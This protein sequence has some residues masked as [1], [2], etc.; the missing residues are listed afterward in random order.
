MEMGREDFFYHLLPYS[1]SLYFLLFSIFQRIWTISVFFIFTAGVN[2]TKL[3]R[4]SLAI[5]LVLF[6]YVLQAQ[7]TVYTYLDSKWKKY[8]Q[9]KANYYRKDY[10]NKNKSWIVTDYYLDGQLQMSGVYKE[11]KLKTRNGKFI[12]YYENGNKE[13]EGRYSDDKREGVWIFWYENRTID[14]KGEYS[15]GKMIGDYVSASSLAPRTPNLLLIP[16]RI[17]I[18]AIGYPLYF[19]F[20][21]LLVNILDLFSRYTG[22][23]AA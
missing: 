17:H 18:V 2:K 3:M 9:E 14:R 1:F 21:E 22:I 11:K 8:K 6:G 4:Y 13:S 16:A 23:Y 20:E 5:F 7:D 12:R 10:R 15:E 19:S